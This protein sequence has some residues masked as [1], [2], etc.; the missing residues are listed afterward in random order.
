MRNLLA[1]STLAMSRIER[2]RRLKLKLE[3]LLVLNACGS[4]TKARHPFG[5]AYHGKCKRKRKHT[6]GDRQVNELQL[7]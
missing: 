2:N 6:E 7:I 4:P 3:H 5:P 1:N